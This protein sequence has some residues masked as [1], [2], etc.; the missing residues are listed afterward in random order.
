MPSGWAAQGLAIVLLIMSAIF[1]YGTREPKLEPLRFDKVERADDQVVLH[2]TYSGGRLDRIDP[3]DPGG[4]TRLRLYRCDRPD[5]LPRTPTYS[6]DV[7]LPRRASG[8]P[9][10]AAV[11]SVKDVS[12]ERISRVF[13]G[14]D[15][16]EGPPVD[17]NNSCLSYVV[18]KHHPFES[19]RVRATTAPGDLSPVGRFC[20]AMKPARSAQVVG[21]ND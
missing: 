17:W 18:S 2:L 7:T 3:A 21:P 13:E 16:V 15:Y 11:I 6:N 12:C 19:T 20:A 5:T 14:T 10:H 9:L 1:F 8:E 4:Y